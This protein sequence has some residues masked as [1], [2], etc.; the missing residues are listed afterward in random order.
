MYSWDDVGLFLVVFGLGAIVVVGIIVF[1]SIFWGV[2][3]GCI[4]RSQSV[5]KSDVNKI[6]VKNN[7]L[8]LC[9][10]LGWRH[11]RKGMFEYR[12]DYDTRRTWR[13]W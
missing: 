11:K 10:R 12:P 4:D 13:G 2:L 1:C 5:S 6:R 7:F 9:D 8:D 3:L